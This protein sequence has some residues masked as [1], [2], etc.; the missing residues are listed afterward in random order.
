ME[1]VKP[2]FTFIFDPV[3]S[4]NPMDLVPIPVN[5]ELKSLLITLMS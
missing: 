1:L 2:A 5:V 3:K 4:T